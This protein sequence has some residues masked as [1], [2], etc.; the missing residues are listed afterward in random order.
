MRLSA[1][2]CYEID[3][4]VLRRVPAGPSQDDAVATWHGRRVDLEAEASAIA[5]V[6]HT[7]TSE[8]NGLWHAMKRELDAV[9]ATIARLSPEAPRH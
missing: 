7:W 2:G 4:T 3:G 5:H 9:A 6:H 1:G 8:E